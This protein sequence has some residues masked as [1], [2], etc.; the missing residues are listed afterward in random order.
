MQDAGQRFS[1]VVA[2]GGDIASAVAIALFRQDH[3]VVLLEGPQP[4]TIRRGMAF[5]DAAF[6]GQAM[7]EG[8]TASRVDDLSRIASHL[9]S[10]HTIPLVVSTLPEILTVASW[11][12]LVDARMR[13]RAQPDRLRGLA[14]LTIGLGPNFV[15]GETV[16]VAIETEWGDELGNVIIAGATRPLRGEP[17]PIAGHARDRYVYAPVAGVFRSDRAIG[18]MVAAEESIAHIGDAILRAPLT[19][20]LR[21]LTRDGVPVEE[22]TKVIEVDPRLKDAVVTGI[23]ERPATIAR[24]VLKAICHAGW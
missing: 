20:T 9:A 16:D 23:S 17:R 24:G 19:G 1:I 14:P 18:D 10:R 13:K 15:A 3:A 5:S 21:G 12:V 22:Q 8:V 4:T 2:G 6:D 7:L 11:E